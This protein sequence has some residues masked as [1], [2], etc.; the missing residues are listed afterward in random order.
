MNGTI[1]PCTNHISHSGLARKNIITTSGECPMD[2]GEWYVIYSI[3]QQLILW[4]R[5]L[6]PSMA[7]EREVI[8][9]VKFQY[10]KYV[11]NSILAHPESFSSTYLCLH[12]WCVTGDQRAK[13]HAVLQ[14][15]PQHCQWQTHCFAMPWNTIWHMF[16]TLAEKE[17]S[18][19][20]SF[21]SIVLCRV[22]H[23]WPCMWR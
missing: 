4:S 7:F 21:N 20:M 9:E 3:Y 1:K 2:R 14:H 5:V 11:Y 10:V 15:N 19:R 8:P 16:A 17:W 23:D 22:A 6:V 13:S 12:Q 18:I